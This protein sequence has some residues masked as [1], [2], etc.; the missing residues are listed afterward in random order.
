VLLGEPDV[1]EWTWTRWQR[2]QGTTVAIAREAG[3]DAALRAW[4]C[5]GRAQVALRDN[6]LSRA[7]ER[8]KVSREELCAR[9][10]AHARS[11]LD[12]FV[13]QLDRATSLGPALLRATLGQDALALPDLVCGDFPCGVRMVA[14]A[15]GARLP[16]LLLN[17][18]ASDA[19]SLNE[20]CST[21]IALAETLP[22]AELALA[23]TETEFSAWLTR[24]RPRDVALLHAGMLRL[25]PQADGAALS[26]AS[27]VTYDENEFAR[28]RAESTLYRRLEQRPRTQG[29]FELNTTLPAR[30]GS[31]N[32][33]VDLLCEDLRVAVE[34]DGYHHFRDEAAYRRDRSLDIELQGLGY[35]VVRVLASDV[36]NEV[37]FVIGMLD[38]VVERQRKGNV[39]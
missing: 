24:A 17:V 3:R 31:S 9:H 10:A 26:Q 33:E 11:Q 38:Q 19:S 2:A 23:T 21:L 29:L 32:L 6:I 22:R 4:L 16:A 35:L 20:A 37:D 1:W 18:S 39:A 8:L 15:L 36:M 34:I 12:V 7:A 25:A 13:E 27:L 5:D 14:P 30:F 28:S